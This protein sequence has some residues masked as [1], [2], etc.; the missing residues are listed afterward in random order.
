[1]TTKIKDALSC[2]ASTGTKPS[3][4]PRR[5]VM[6]AWPRWPRQAGGLVHRGQ[7]FVPV[8]AGSRRG[9][10]LREASFV[11][12]WAAFS[13][14]LTVL[15]VLWSL[16][17]PV[18]SGPDEPTQYVK[19]AA[20]AGGQVT[21][22]H[23]AGSP[24]FDTQ[25]QV[26]AAVAQ[27]PAGTDCY[28]GHPDV[29]AGCAPRQFGPPGTALA[30]TYVG[31]YPPLYY[32]LTGLPNLVSAGRLSLH[33]MR[34]VSALI[35]SL[36]LGL[37]FA[38]AVRWSRSRFLLP[39][40]SLA[41]T[42]E[43]IYLLSVLNPNGFE[44][45]AAAALWTSATILL[46]EQSHDPPPALVA[47][48]VVSALLLTFTR[49]LSPV[50]VV[51]ILASLVVLRPSAARRLLT[52][53]C[54][55]WG[56][57]VIAM[58]LVLSGAYVLA[59]RSYEVESFP[60]PP[61]TTTAQITRL[62]ILAVPG[63]LSD[64]FGAYGSP[65]TTAPLVVVLT[66]GLA[67]TVLVGVALALARRYDAAVLTGLTAAFL[68]VLPLAADA[69]TARSHGVVWQGRY[70]YPLAI[71]IPIVAATLIAQRAA[72]V[73]QAA[74][75]LAPATACLGLLASYYWIFHRY[76]VGL[77]GPLNPLRDTPGA[78]RPPV[79][80]RLLLP[81]TLVT[82]VAYAIT[83]HRSCR[84]S[85]ATSKQATAQRSGHDDSSN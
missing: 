8:L 37:A 23:P 65:D 73:A 82:T 21:G 63:Y 66:W 54:A 2:R 45:V 42:P 41:V 51:T 59:E 46:C 80:A 67:L 29:G 6:T 27:L 78:W 17:T 30:V 9:L 4:C 56:L 60:L 50:W 84:P 40:L 36:V 34:A 24:R 26:P 28:Y 61:G 81:L 44:I 20:V 62:V 22:T 14:L 5:E 55:R 7:G 35:G 58:G 33:A 47:V 76:A 19:S 10:S 39:A 38:T 69:L 68:V 31:R 1:V 52:F 77:A 49:P 13:L 11:R 48:A 85:P 57:T 72:P 64:L 25:V 18:P 70:E 16:A 53:N 71:G 3:P 15:T 75:V 12:T 83:V 32:A 43:A 74:A 79:P